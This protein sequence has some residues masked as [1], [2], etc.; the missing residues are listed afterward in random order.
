MGQERITV[1]LREE[2]HQALWELATRER[3]DPRDQAALAI[4]RDLERRGLLSTD[5][6]DARG[7][8]EEVAEWQR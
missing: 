2:E 1:W 6:H 5:A 8:G 4:R 3:R 7:A